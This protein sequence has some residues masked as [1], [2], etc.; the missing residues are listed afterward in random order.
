MDT[1]LVVTSGSGPY[2]GHCGTPP[3][4]VKSYPISKFGELIRLHPVDDSDVAWLQNV[5]PKVLAK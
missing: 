4:I 5:A 3:H 2:I 1:L